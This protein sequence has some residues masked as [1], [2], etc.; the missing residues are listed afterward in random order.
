ML[1]YVL[2]LNFISKTL[3]SVAKKSTA[4]FGRGPLRLKLHTS[5][6]LISMYLSVHSDSFHSMDNGKV[7]AIVLFDFDLSVV[8]ATVDSAVLCCLASLPWALVFIY[9]QALNWFQSY[10]T[11]HMQSVFIINVRTFFCWWCSTLNFIWLFLCIQLS[12][13]LSDTLTDFFG[14]VHKFSLG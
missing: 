11:P 12:H 1:H 5:L 4:H 8:F 3:E 10:R 13:L 14:H 9:G 2:N 6:F 7:T